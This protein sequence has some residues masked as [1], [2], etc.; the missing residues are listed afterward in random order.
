MK[1]IPIPNATAAQQSAIAALVDKILAAKKALTGAQASPLANRREAIKA[2]EEKTAS[3]TLALQSW[4]AEID[5]LVYQLYG[6]TNEE[7][8]IVEGKA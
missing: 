2:Q 6:L 8:A 4:E 3:E 5:A 7:I 1:Q